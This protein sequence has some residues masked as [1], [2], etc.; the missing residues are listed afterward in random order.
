MWK[1]AH[2]SMHAIGLRSLAIHVTAEPG[3][4]ERYLAQTR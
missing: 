3:R 1:A 4:L 2:V